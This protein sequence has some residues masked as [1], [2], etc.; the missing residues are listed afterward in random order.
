MEA[1]S[2]E[3]IEGRQDYRNLL[4]RRAQL[5]FSLKGKVLIAH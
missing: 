4:T 5:S 1:V 3:I 2:L